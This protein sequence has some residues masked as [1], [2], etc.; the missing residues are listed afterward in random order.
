[1]RCIAAGI[2]THRLLTEEEVRQVKAALALAGLTRQEFAE[3]SGVGYSSITK[4]LSRRRT[5]APG[6]AKALNKLLRRTRWPQR[7][8]A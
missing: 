7:N 2:E 5:P 6:H 8:G 1:M 4:T 3:R